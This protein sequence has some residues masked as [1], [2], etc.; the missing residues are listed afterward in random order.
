MPGNG[1]LGRKTMTI[2]DEITLYFGFR[3]FQTTPAPPRKWH[4]IVRKPKE[5]SGI[6][7]ENLGN[8][9]QT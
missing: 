3:R 2:N 4:R 6:A 8:R 1:K 9:R 7:K 5:N